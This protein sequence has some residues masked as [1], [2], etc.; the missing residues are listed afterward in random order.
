[1]FIS[2]INERKASEQI[3]ILEVENTHA[4]ASISLFGA[5]VLSFRPKHDGRE[6]LFLSTCTRWDGS[7]SIRGGI[8]LCWPWFGAHKEPEK[9]PAWQATFNLP[10]HCKHGCSTFQSELR[11][12]HLLCGQ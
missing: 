2:M 10:D 11:T 9:Y 6:R 12:P 1:M 8:P 3:T 7:K 4:S 5:Q